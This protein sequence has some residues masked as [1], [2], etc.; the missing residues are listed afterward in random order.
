M[1]QNVELAYVDHGYT[2][3]PA[4]RQ[5]QEHGMQLVGGQP[6]AEKGFVRLP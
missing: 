2:G 1:G 3:A 6:E 4:K 5:T